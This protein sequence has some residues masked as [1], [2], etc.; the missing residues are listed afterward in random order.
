MEEPTA[1]LLNVEWEPINGCDVVSQSIS[2]LCP[3]RLKV[4][5]RGIVKL[6]AA[7]RQGPH[8]QGLQQ[9]EGLM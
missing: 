4:V 3:Q 8:L 1:L 5:D 2:L 6:L 7:P 9:W